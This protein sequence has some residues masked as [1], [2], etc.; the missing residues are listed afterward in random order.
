MRF[1]FKLF[2]SH[3]AHQ[4][5]SSRCITR[6]NCWLKSL[7]FERQKRYSMPVL[8]AEETHQNSWRRAAA[9]IFLVG[10]TAD[11]THWPLLTTSAH[12]I[13]LFPWWLFAWELS[14]TQIWLVGNG[15]F[16]LYFIDFSTWKC[17]WFRSKN[18]LCILTFPS[19]TTL[20]HKSY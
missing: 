7:A 18:L 3:T 17:I 1:S 8:L 5:N 14:W 15:L 2:W 19:A 12:V 20:V 13:E 16:N 6:S 11:H 9:H 10:E 4:W